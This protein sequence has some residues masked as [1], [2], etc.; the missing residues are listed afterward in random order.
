MNKKINTVLFILGAT[1]LNIILMI[2]IMTFGLALI[3][4]FVGDTVSEAMAS[5]VFLL[6][7]IVSIGGAFFIYHRLV[8]FISR[9]IDME[10]HFHP[11][12]RR[13]KE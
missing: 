12:F 2:L 7:F 10:K 1:V 5:I 6:L 11:I 9:K 3:S 8:G 4:I 13:K